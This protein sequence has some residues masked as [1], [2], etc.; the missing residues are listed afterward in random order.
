METVFIRSLFYTGK[1]F[2]LRMMTKYFKSPPPTHT[3]TTQSYYTSALCF[4][5]GY[6]SGWSVNDV[7]IALFE[8]Y[9][10]VH[11]DTKSKV[12]ELRIVSLLHRFYEEIEVTFS[13]LLCKKSMLLFCAVKSKLMFIELE[14]SLLVNNENFFLYFQMLEYRS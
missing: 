3:H 14:R 9:Y 7:L 10:K 13:A 1:R 5:S 4:V 12:K 2:S 8:Y 6:A 11:L